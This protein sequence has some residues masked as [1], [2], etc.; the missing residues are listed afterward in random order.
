M[1]LPRGHG[2]ERLDSTWVTPTAFVAYMYAWNQRADE[3]ELDIARGTRLAIRMTP[4]ERALFAYA[5]ALASHDLTALLP[6]ATEFMRHTPGSMESPLLVSSTA[7]GLRQPD[8]AERALRETASDRGM[9][10]VGPYY[11]QNRVGLAPLRGDRGAGLAASRA[12]RRRVP[13]WVVVGAEGGYPR[14]VVE[15]NDGRRKKGSRVAGGVVSSGLDEAL[16][17]VKMICG[18][19]VAEAVQVSIQYFPKPPV[20]GTLPSSSP[21]P[22]T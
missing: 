16:Q 15:D 11:W 17:L 10:L 5:R 21:C 13:P 3:L 14:F 22:L 12:G 2:A 19:H 4:A 7:L 9:N 18:E 20:N 1:I 8:V 6:A